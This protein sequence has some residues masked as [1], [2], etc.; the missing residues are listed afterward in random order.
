MA[1]TGARNFTAQRMHSIGQTGVI[2]VASRRLEERDGHVVTREPGRLGSVVLFE[3]SSVQIHESP[4][5]IHRQTT[6]SSRFDLLE[7]AQRSP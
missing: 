4:V 7:R 6:S 5:M 2:P 3:L 1:I